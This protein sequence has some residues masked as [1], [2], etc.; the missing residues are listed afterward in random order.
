MFNDEKLKLQEEDAKMGKKRA[1]R[2]KRSVGRRFN[3][4]KAKLESINECF[5]QLRQ[6]LPA[7]RQEYVDADRIT[8]SYVKSCF[9]MIIQRAVDINNVIIEFS[10]Q[11]PPQQKHRGFRVLCESS[12]IDRKTLD[13]FVQALEC[14]DRIANP[15]Q[16]LTP[17]ELYNASVRL[18]TYGETYAAQLEKFF[19]NSSSVKN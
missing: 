10:G 9:L 16:E 18:L 5:D 7:T 17:S 13:F 3:P 19:V 2:T 15:Y 1:K 4:V 12:V 11:T 6:G 14:Y 8:H